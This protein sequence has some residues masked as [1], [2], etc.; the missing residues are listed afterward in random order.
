MAIRKTISLNGVSEILFS[1][2][3]RQTSMI[4]NDVISNSIFTGQVLN[5]LIKFLSK[6]EIEELKKSL[7]INIAFNSTDINPHTKEKPSP[8]NHIQETKNNHKK[9][10]YQKELETEVINDFNI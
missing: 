9:I 3:G 10:G 4:I 7:P 1:K 5:S 8:P 6:E 2:T